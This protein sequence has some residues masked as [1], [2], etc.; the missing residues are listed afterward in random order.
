MRKIVVYFLLLVALGVHGQKSSGPIDPRSY[1]FSNPYIIP[2][3]EN[4]EN[5]YLLI[6]AGKPLY[7]TINGMDNG[8]TYYL[9]SGSTNEIGNLQNNI[10]LMTK[11]GGWLWQ[12]TINGI[13][14]TVM[15]QV[16]YQ[17]DLQDQTIG[18]ATYGDYPDFIRVPQGG[19]AKVSA[20]PNMNPT[21]GTTSG[22]YSWKDVNT[23]V[24]LTN[25]SIA[26]VDSVKNLLSGIIR[27]RTNDGTG[28]WT[29]DTISILEKPTFNPTAK[30]L[31][32]PTT[33]SGISYKLLKVSTVSGNDT[34][35]TETHNVAGDGNARTLNLT[36]G[37]YKLTVT[38]GIYT[39]TYPYGYFRPGITT[40]VNTAKVET[41]NYRLVGN[42]LQ[43]D[44]EVHL[45]FYSL[46][47]QILQQ[48]QGSAFTLAHQ[49]GIFT[50]I[51]KNGNTVREKIMVND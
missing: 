37:T 11:A 12:Y 28:Y 30:T 36:D 17:A 43:F 31:N 46:Q 44:R 22:A 14:N 39:A 51:D 8:S 48:A 21:G 1:S 18:S 16:N 32:F 29:A 5:F 9:K 26:F 33:V 6:K 15:V 35:W 2:T 41:I 34:T 13:G 3:L 4:L 40:A 49:T 45:K 23:G 47:G 50:A 27:G 24:V 38:R 19:S 25:S 20:G 42:N 10:I 7:V